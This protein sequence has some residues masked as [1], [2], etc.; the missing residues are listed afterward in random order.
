MG[1]LADFKSLPDYA[2]E[3]PSED[4]YKNGV[5]EGSPVNPKNLNWALRELG[6]QGDELSK[7]EDQ[8]TAELKAHGEA[9]EGT[10]LRKPFRSVYTPSDKTVY[11]TLKAFTVRYI[12]YYHT[13][14]TYA[15][16]VVSNSEN[17]INIA[18][19]M[20]MWGGALSPQG[21][22]YYE[23]AREL[24]DYV[25][26]TKLISETDRSI[27]LASI[28]SATPV[29]NIFS[30]YPN[31]SL[32][33]QPLMGIWNYQKVE[34]Y[35]DGEYYTKFIKGM[36]KLFLQTDNVSN[37]PK[38]R[39]ILAKF[40]ENT[41]AGIYSNHKATFSYIIPVFDDINEEVIDKEVFFNTL[42]RHHIFTSI[43]TQ[44][45]PPKTSY[46]NIYGDKYKFSGRSIGYSQFINCML[47]L[48]EKYRGKDC[49]SAP[50]DDSLLGQHIAT[51]SLDELG[52]NKDRMYNDDPA[53]NG[54]EKV[55]IAYENVIENYV[56]ATTHI[57]TQSRGGVFVQDYC[58]TWPENVNYKN[59]SSTEKRAREK[60]YFERGI[61]ASFLRDMDS[62][63]D[64]NN[65]GKKT[66]PTI[67]TGFVTHT[68]IKIKN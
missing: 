19:S 42:K 56:T 29:D 34:K 52:M 35:P 2:C 57:P 59:Y 65:A 5:I 43:S 51:N 39:N 63:V 1:K 64:T 54:R 47:P 8:Y 58:K 45:G 17:I 60:M 33:H 55:R 3:E 30:S 9:L 41:L 48:K 26:E 38:D 21:V 23:L 68:Y 46:T 66:S 15:N 62:I 18:R 12:P 20:G 49:K 4:I 50:I 25:T 36:L 14:T 67:N 13:T 11:N 28:G 7:I 24:K 10:I 16:T 6:K 37:D 61:G 53:L 27:I 40:A 44:V 32:V 22:K 31:T